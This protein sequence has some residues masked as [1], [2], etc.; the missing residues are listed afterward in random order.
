M[1]RRHSVKRPAASA[2]NAVRTPVNAN[3]PPQRLRFWHAAL[4]FGALLTIVL[5]TYHP[6]W[7]GGILWDDEGHLTRPEL[8][9]WHGLWRIWFDLGATQQY[10]PLV[11]STFWLLA[12]L[13]G[14]GTLA[15]HLLNLVLH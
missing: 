11:H 10:Y 15:P 1:S 13:W 9:S 6:A 14:G 12:M 5:A 8:Q 3:P 7:Y 4:L 2:S